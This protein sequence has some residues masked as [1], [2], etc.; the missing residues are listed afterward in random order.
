MDGS[1]DWD[2]ETDEESN[3]SD[4]VDNRYCQ[5][6]RAGLDEDTTAESDKFLLNWAFMRSPAGQNLETKNNVKGCHE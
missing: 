5:D 4:S 2:S 1:S 6:H 3:D